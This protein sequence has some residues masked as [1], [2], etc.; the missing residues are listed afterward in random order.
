[1]EKRAARAFGESRPRFKSGGLGFRFLRYEFV[2]A[3]WYP[4]VNQVALSFFHDK[5]GRDDRGGEKWINIH[6][7]ETILCESFKAPKIR[8]G[9][10]RGEALDLPVMRWGWVTVE[11]RQKFV[12]AN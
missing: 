2:G 6:K 8:Q 3:G 12:C 1:M 9:S 7:R 10:K 5:A 4:A 11:A